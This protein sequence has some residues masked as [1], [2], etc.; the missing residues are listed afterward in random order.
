M[1]RDDV[2]YFHYTESAGELQE[3]SSGASRL[4]FTKP[5]RGASGQHPR[6][7]VGAD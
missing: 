5:P 1:R 6:T 7:N 3:A 2:M 4:V